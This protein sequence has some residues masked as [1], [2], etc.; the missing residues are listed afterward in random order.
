MEG[1]GGESEGIEIVTMNR[2]NQ[3][4]EGKEYSSLPVIGLKKICWN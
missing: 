2:N 1:D 4:G 3:L